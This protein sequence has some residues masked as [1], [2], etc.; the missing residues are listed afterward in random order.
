MQCAKAPEWRLKCK[1]DSNVT[2]GINYIEEHLADKLDLEIVGK[3]VHYLKYH[4]H[5]IGRQKNF[6][7]CSYDI[8]YMRNLQ[9]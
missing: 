1:K 4:L 8:C 7:Q 2:A 9:N 6:I 3:A 5:H